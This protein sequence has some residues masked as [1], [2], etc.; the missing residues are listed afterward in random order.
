MALES[1]YLRAQLMTEVTPPETNHSW[2]EEVFSDESSLTFEVSPQHE[3][4]L[5]RRFELICVVVICALMALLIT[6]DLALCVL[7]SVTL[8]LLAISLTERR[9]IE[10]ALDNIK[11]EW[12]VPESAR[13]GEEARLELRFTNQ[14]PVDL[15]GL[16]VALRGPVGLSSIAALHL[17]PH[18]TAGSTYT[19]VGHVPCPHYCAGKI[20]GAE[21]YFI[22]HLGLIRS[23]RHIIAEHL[24]H[25]TPG[26]PLIPWGTL[27]FNEAR[28]SVIAHD[29]SVNQA[30]SHD[31][32]F[33]ELRPYVSSDHWRA[34]AWR[35]SARRGQLMTRTL[36]QSRERRYVIALDVSYAMRAPLRLSES[37]TLVDFAL[38][39]V[40]HWVAQTKEDQVGVIV[41]D[42]RALVHIPVL[43]RAHLKEQLERLLHYTARPLDADCTLDTLD[44]LW[45]RAAHYLEWS[46][47]MSARP[48]LTDHVSMYA[49]SS[50]LLT[51]SYQLGVVSSY[52]DQLDV[53]GVLDHLKLDEVALHDRLRKL[54][55][56]AGV[57]MQP[58]LPPPELEWNQGLREVLNFSKRE[59]AT[60]LVM[61]SSRE[62]LQSQSGRLMLRR[63]AS[64]GGALQTLDLREVVARSSGRLKRGSESKINSS[65]CRWER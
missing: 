47:V 2:D 50:H 53:R 54:L 4:S 48:D 31:G 12:T 34:I 65:V 59:R 52:L 43:P 57:V 32:D 55:H 6:P 8:T 26:R 44:E 39:L 20:W 13:R 17:T 37:E 36:E 42:H 28:S 10:E 27:L 15:W 21:L 49:F 40:S 23:T 35:P 14:S 18:Q 51:T 9:D 5:T 30:R 58:K 46:G 62:R 60:H 45:S 33:S 7:F 16:E 41:F 19:L 25:I 56:R 61:L 3:R 11:I 22:S 64:S 63:W 24:I 29:Q 1:P 38:D